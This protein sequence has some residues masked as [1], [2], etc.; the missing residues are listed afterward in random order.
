MSAAI[1]FHEAIASPLHAPESASRRNFSASRNLSRSRAHRFASHRKI[2]HRYDRARQDR[3]FLQTDPIGYQ[4]D[5]NLYQYVRND[6]VN[7]ADPSGRRPPDEDMIAAHAA[8]GYVPPDASTYERQQ[9]YVDRSVRA[10]QQAADQAQAVRV[11]NAAIRIA[12]ENIDPARDAFQAAASGAVDLIDPVKS[13]IKDVMRDIVVEE[14]SGVSCGM[15]VNLSWKRRP[16][17]P[18]V[19]LRA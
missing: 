15:L 6:P 13:P 8:G 12:G 16:L 19:W 7:L 17:L 2:S 9:E 1:R 5:L 3:Q 4:D 18:K 14:A 11:D 10:D